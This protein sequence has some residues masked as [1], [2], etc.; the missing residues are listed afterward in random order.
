MDKFREG[1]VPFPASGLSPQ[2]LGQ[3]AELLGSL[4]PQNLSRGLVNVAAKLTH[5]KDVRDLFVD[6]VEKVS[7]PACCAYPQPGL[8]LRCT[9]TRCSFGPTVR[10]A[11]PL[12]PLAIE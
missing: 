3:K 12:R 5:N 10:G 2:P 11:L 1:P 8:Y 4:S 9:S 6:L 7:C